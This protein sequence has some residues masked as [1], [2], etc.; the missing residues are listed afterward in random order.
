VGYTVRIYGA[1]F[2]HAGSSASPRFEQVRTSALLA[3]H[4]LPHDDEYPPLTCNMISLTADDYRTPGMYR[5]LVLH[6]GL[7]LK[8]GVTGGDVW[9]V[10]LDKFESFLERTPWT[11]ARLHLELEL[12]PGGHLSYRWEL[13]PGDSLAD[14]ATWRFEGGPRE[15]GE[16]VRRFRKAAAEAEAGLRSSPDDPE[17]LERMIS[18]CGRLRRFEDALG[19]LERLRK[20]DPERAEKV[21][22]ESLASWA[23]RCLR[24]GQR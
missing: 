10:W 20:V 21:P 2:C 3:L 5:E 11:S 8:D 22:V 12:P 4:L 6:L 7:T 18:C 14:R 13:C 19:Y 9:D 1:I 23:D 17:L 24:G 15:L 16:R